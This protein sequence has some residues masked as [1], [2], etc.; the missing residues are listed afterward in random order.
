MKFKHQSG[1]LLVVA[2]FLIVVVAALGI[3]ITS[4][5]T[6][7][8]K[9]GVDTL[10]ATLD[11]VKKRYPAFP[12]SEIPNVP[13]EE[14]PPPSPIGGPTLQLTQGK[15]SGTFTIT[16]SNKINGNA[17]GH[18]IV[19][20]GSGVE[21]TGG[22]TATGKVTLGSATKIGKN[23]CAIGLVDMNNGAVVG[24]DIHSH[25][26]SVTVGSSSATVK[27]NIYSAGNVTLGSNVQL[28]E[29]TDIHAAGNVTLASGVILVGSIYAGGSVEFKSSNVRVTGDVHANGGGVTFGWNTAIIGDVVA[30]GVISNTSS[31]I[32]GDAFAAQSI[33]SNVNVSGTKHPNT[34]PSSLPLIAPTPPEAC[35][36]MCIPE[37]ATFTAGGSNYPA[38][39]QTDRT[40]TEG[41]YGDVGVG[42]ESKLYLSAGNYWFN[43][44]NANNNLASMYLDISS[45]DINIFVVNDAVFGSSFN[46]FVKVDNDSEYEKIV[47]AGRHIKASL[48]PYAER[49]YME[50]HGNVTFNNENSWFGTIFSKGNIRF[51]NEN[52]LV[53]AYISSEG[54]VTT[55]NG[56]QV[57]FVPSNYGSENWTFTCSSQGE[58]GNGGESG[59]SVAALQLLLDTQ[60]FTGTNQI[61]F[62]P[63]AK[64]DLDTLDDMTLA[65]WLSPTSFG[66]V[67]AVVSKGGMD[68]EVG[69]TLLIDSEGYLVFQ[70]QT[71]AFVRSIR[72][73]IPLSAGQWHHVAA[74]LDR[75]TVDT[76]IP[77][78]MRLYV[79]KVIQNGLKVHSDSTVTSASLSNSLLLTVGAHNA[80]PSVYAHY[81]IGQL[82][83]G[84]LYP[85][86]LTNSNIAYL[87]ESQKIGYE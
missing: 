85:Q 44:I 80:S 64:G 45:G 11:Q 26:S 10:S 78:Q 69:Y 73:D 12:D 1:S 34:P 67:Q 17:A 63:A 28:E 29:G 24:G 77:F 41:S 68:G 46:V 48:A 7:T 83:N 47:D 49:V 74:V 13:G 4:V 79:N 3:A 42:G 23:I 15:S 33:G 60:E 5:F 21:I 20:N 62:E 9:G 76:V 50:T 39:W 53:G 72:S 8:S 27:G 57:H 56:M 81:F 35:P 71:P 6:N 38:Q 30:N 19:T 36:E 87:Y 86:V 22:I 84:A 54:T 16:S 55:W 52:R 32:T 82:G 65:L 31:S 70:V 43:R 18:D 61:V 51:G 40:L 25:G 66:Q 75:N 58:G 59:G 14:E 37:H 2:I